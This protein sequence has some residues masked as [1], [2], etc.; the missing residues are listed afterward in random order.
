MLSFD[1]FLVISR[2][3][4]N[5][6]RRKSGKIKCKTIKLYLQNLHYFSLD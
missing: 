4:V 2:I 1:F 5:I 6:L 3:V